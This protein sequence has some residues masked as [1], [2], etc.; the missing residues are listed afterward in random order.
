M[1]CFQFI[2]HFH[3]I[4]YYFMPSISSFRLC[5]S[6]MDYIP[7]FDKALK[8]VI[9]SISNSPQ[10]KLEEKEFY[11][12]FEGSFGDFAVSPRS[13]SSQH[14]GK[15]ISIEGIVTRCKSTNMFFYFKFS[16]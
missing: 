4:M 1:V 9:L 15:L 13:L 14:L 2:V 16:N 8:E 11:V 7:P 3:L 5:K 10:D 6:P 12:G